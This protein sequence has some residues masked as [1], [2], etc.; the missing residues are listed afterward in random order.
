[1]SYDDYD[2]DYHNLAEDAYYIEEAETSS[3]DCYYNDGNDEPWMGLDK[4]EN[5]ALDF[6]GWENY[7]HNIANELVDE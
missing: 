4:N 7:Y 2:Y 6:K 1:M 3:D 5:E